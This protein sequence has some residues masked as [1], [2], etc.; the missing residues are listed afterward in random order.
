M[1]PKKCQ[2]KYKSK[3]WFEASVGVINVLLKSDE[4][5]VKE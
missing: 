5:L 2:L 4:V 3:N 1:R